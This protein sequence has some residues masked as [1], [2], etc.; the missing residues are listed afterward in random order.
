MTV[1]DSRDAEP[2]QTRGPGGADRDSAEPT[3]TKSATLVAPDVDAPSAPADPTMAGVGSGVE[4]AVADLG[5]GRGPSWL[6]SWL[7]ENSPRVVA[8]RRH[9]HANP[10][11]SR[12]EYETTAFLREKLTSAGL[13]PR[14]LP[15]GTGLICDIGRG[16]KTIALRADIDALPLTES[17]GLPFSS[18]VEGVAHACGHDAHTTVLLGTALV[19]ANAPELPGRIRLIF[20]PA[21]E[22]MPGGALDVLATGALDGVDRIFGLHCDPRLPVGSIGTRVGAITSASDLLELRLSSPGGH[23][24]R[25]HLTADLV[26]GLGSVITGLPM[27]LSRRVDP[28]T[29]TV[30]TWGAVHA[31]EAPNA[32]PQNG[33]LTGTL[34][35]GDRTTWAKLEPLVHELVHSLLSPLGIGFDLQ[36][37]RGVPPVV[38]DSESTEIL[39]AGVVA[40]LGE[41]ALASTPQSSGGEDFGWY[42]EHVP[43]SFARLGVHSGVGRVKDLHQPTFTLDERALLVGIRVMVNTALQALKN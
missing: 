28:R 23:T 3:G 10:E 24:S 30:L 40:G 25:P 43:G 16:S 2:G 32:I 20:Q 17:T 35:T 36:H 26:H 6:D 5:A 12:A 15:K 8:W 11:L 34:R 14:V 41:Q 1:V 38:N 7:R 31:G 27:L 39:R 13:R 22:V 21:E 33:V 29:G 37:R 42:L 4:S 19:L 18:T 9:I